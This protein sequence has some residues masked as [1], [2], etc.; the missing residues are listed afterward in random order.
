MRIKKA[1][2]IL[3]ILGLFFLGP[4]DQFLILFLVNLVAL[5]S[6]LWSALSVV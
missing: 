6:V 2:E 5:G 1:I 3:F 4:V